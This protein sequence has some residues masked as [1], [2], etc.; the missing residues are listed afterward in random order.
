MPVPVVP[1][2]AAAAAGSV[3]LKPA[4]GHVSLSPDGRVRISDGFNDFCCCGGDCPE[5]CVAC[6]ECCF[7]PTSTAL[8]TIEIFQCWWLG[9]DCSGAPDFYRSVKFENDLP[10]SAD[11]AESWLENGECVWSAAET[12]ATE[13]NAPDDGDVP[14]ECEYV[15]PTG[16]PYDPGAFTVKY[17]CETAQ[18]S[19]AGAMIGE[20]GVSGGDCSGVTMV[21]LVTGYDCIDDGGGHRTTVKY[22]FTITVAD[23][24]DCM[25]V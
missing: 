20:L 19:V 10:L 1:R 11:G 9:E 22:R 25:A 12:V 14:E 24:D 17:D 4:T 13:F 23:N 21:E 3:L 16:T 15:E 18:W 8:F 5:G 6:G 7:S 2:R